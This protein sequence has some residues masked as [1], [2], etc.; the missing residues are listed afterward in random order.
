MNTTYCSGIGRS[1]PRSCRMRTR[2][3]AAMFEHVGMRTR[4]T[5]LEP[6]VYGVQFR[7]PKFP[8]AII[9]APSD[10]YFDP[11]GGLY[12][13]LLPGGLMATWDNQQG[14]AKMAG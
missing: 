5:I 13:L 12:R 2:A 1:S 3:M 10:Q 6:S 7:D 4:I 8:V 14:L 9:A 11:D